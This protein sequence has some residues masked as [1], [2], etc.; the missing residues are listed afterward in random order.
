M[1]PIVIQ[2]RRLLGVQQDLESAAEEITSAAGRVDAPAA[3][4]PWHRLVEEGVRVLLEDSRRMAKKCRHV[5]GS[6]ADSVTDF[7]ELDGYVAIAAQLDQVSPHP[8]AQ[9]LPVQDPADIG[10]P[11]VDR[12]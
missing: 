8:V 9:P 2:R 12:A 6:V 3:D 10:R 5:A 4:Y 1:R 11:L 7:A